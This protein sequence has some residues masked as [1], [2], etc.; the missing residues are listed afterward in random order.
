MS[1]EQKIAELLAESKKSAVVAEENN[2]TVAD[3]DKSEPTGNGANEAAEGVIRQGDAVK[4]QG[5]T[6]HLSGA[7]SRLSIPGRSLHDYRRRA[8][9][10][11]PYCYAS[12]LAR[13][14]LGI[15][16]L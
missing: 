11:R 14:L 5:E 6:P 16:E 15:C 3:L 7:Q 10:N 1:I 2:K 9:K 12:V 13:K 8:C 4:A